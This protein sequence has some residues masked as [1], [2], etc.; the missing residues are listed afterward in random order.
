MHISNAQVLRVFQLH[1]H[2]VH[3]SGVGPGASVGQPDRLTLSRQATEMQNI[4]QFVSGLP[5]VRHDKVCDLRRMVDEGAYQ[6]SD[7]DVA[8]AMFAGALK[9]KGGG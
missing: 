3:A 5:D 9:D 4:K 7:H 8:S 2:K 6:V 1:V